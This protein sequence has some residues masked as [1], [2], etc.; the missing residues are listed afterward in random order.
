MLTPSELKAL[1]HERGLRLTKAL[2]QNHL[3]DPRAIERIIAA[4][5]LSPRDTVVEIGAGL[6]AL[7]EPLAAQSARVIALEVDRGVCALLQERLG[8]HPTIEIRCQDVLTMRW[9]QM[10]GLVV[11]GAIPYHITS[12]I[13]VALS[14]ARHAIA[15][16]VLIVQAEVAQRLTAKPGTKA[17]G[18]L[19]VLGQYA[20]DIRVAAAIPRSAFFPQP[21]VDSICLVLQ[22]RAAPPVRVEHERWFFQVVKTAFG[23]RR[24]TL[25][26]CLIGLGLTR[27]AVEEALR[28]LGLRTDI[29]GE[30]LSLVQF[31]SLAAHLR[32]PAR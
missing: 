18:R 8:A 2:G 20:W 9:D 23:Q 5:E 21:A 30:E 22:P 7:T 27:T 19:T 10:P 29:R 14:E 6:G 17:Y 12:D 24:K 25:A 28:S 16:A 11:V 15:R 32:R 26:N 13:L 3:I 1:L 4:C 31:A